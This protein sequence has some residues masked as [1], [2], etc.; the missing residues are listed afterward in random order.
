MKAIKGALD[1]LES[2]LRSN[3]STMIMDVD[4]LSNARTELTQLK[5]MLREMEW[6][7]TNSVG[8]KVVIED[9]HMCPSCWNTANEGHKPDCRLYL[10]IK[11]E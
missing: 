9:E 4:T 6:S 8:A 2:L 7:A 3:K 11:E 5:Q 10:L 1:L